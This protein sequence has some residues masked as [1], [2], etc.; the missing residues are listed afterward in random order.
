M[1]TY[2]HVYIPHLFYPFVFDGHLGC[3]LILS[4]VNN[5]AV[6]IGVPVSFSLSLGIY[7]GVELLDHV[8]V[9]F[10]VLPGT[11]ILFST[12]VASFTF[13]PAVYKGSIFSHSLREY[14]F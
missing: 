13:P 7:P 12:V 6:N 4:I 11:C 9:L 3:F 10:L 8:V 1:G 2:E 5:A 14:D